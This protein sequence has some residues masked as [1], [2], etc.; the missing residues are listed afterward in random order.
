MFPEQIYGVFIPLYK[1][2][3]FALFILLFPFIQHFALSAVTPERLEHSAL[4]L[5]SPSKCVVFNNWKLKHAALK[6]ACMFAEACL[7]QGWDWKSERRDTF[8]PDTF[9]FIWNSKDVY[10]GHVILSCK[11]WS[12]VW[13]SYLCWFRISGMNSSNTARIIKDYLA[14]GLDSGFHLGLR[15]SLLACACTDLI[16]LHFNFFLHHQPNTTVEIECSSQVLM[17]AESLFSEHLFFATAELLFFQS[18]LLVNVITDTHSDMI[19]I[20]L[21]PR[22]G[23][24]SFSFT[25]ER[26]GTLTRAQVAALDRCCGQSSC[27]CYCVAALRCPAAHFSFGS[28]LGSWPRWID[29]E[30]R[31]THKYGGS[32]TSKFGLLSPFDFKSST[33]LLNEVFL[34]PSPWRLLCE[35]SRVCV[36]V[37]VRTGMCLACVHSLSSLLHCI[38]VQ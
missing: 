28:L 26:V 10:I 29:E 14:K 33:K 9:R 7:M 3:S 21:G 25:R 23:K 17:H 20:T 5:L 37:C 27:R 11:D 22:G 13:F 16:M 32:M 18:T 31:W 38:A 30:R 35:F 34:P 12:I 4:A 19:P 24:L 1:L 2:L 6:G 15:S 8:F 36:C